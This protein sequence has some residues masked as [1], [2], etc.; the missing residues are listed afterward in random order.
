MH[1]VTIN[2]VMAQISNCKNKALKNIHIILSEK[3]AP[4]WV[5]K[6]M[7][8]W[9]NPRETTVLHRY[10]MSLENNYIQ[11][12]C[13]PEELVHK[14]LLIFKIVTSLTNN[15]LNEEEKLSRT[16]DIIKKYLI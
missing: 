14:N 7:E 3:P 12:R 2:N 16:S 8:I 13:A 11:L 4:E 15:K 9:F 6:F 10:N 5:K 1:S